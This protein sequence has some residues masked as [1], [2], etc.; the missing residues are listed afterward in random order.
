MHLQIPS[1]LAEQLARLAT[2]TGRTA[3]E[4]ALD[5][6]RNSVEH[7]EWF[8]AEVEK[9]RLSATEG[10]LLDHQE[11]VARMESRYRS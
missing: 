9:G 4:V 3:D 8:R 6:L 2:Q 5:L 7:D 1:E 11:V 10:T